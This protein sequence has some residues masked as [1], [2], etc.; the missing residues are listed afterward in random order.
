MGLGLSKALVASIWSELAPLGWARPSLAERSTHFLGIYPTGDGVEEEAAVEG[1]DAEVA[2][3]AAAASKDSESSS[4]KFLA[5]REMSAADGDGGY[6]K[7][8]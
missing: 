2:R 8:S 3:Q 7:M 4:Q 5:K 1:E 6:S